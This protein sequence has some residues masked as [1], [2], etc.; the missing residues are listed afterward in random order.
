MWRVFSRWPREAMEE[1]YQNG[2]LRSLWAAP[3]FYIQALLK[4]VDFQ[5]SS[6]ELPL[7]KELE[8]T[9]AGPRGAPFFMSS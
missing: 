6:G 7:R 4:E 2:Q 9:A 1:I 5:E 3:G 8:E